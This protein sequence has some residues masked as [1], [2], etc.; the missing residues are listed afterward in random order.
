MGIERIQRLPSLLNGVLWLSCV[1]C[2]CSHRTTEDAWPL[3]KGGS[4]LPERSVP[5]QVPNDTHSAL[6]QGNTQPSQEEA[7]WTLGSFWVFISHTQKI[8]RLSAGAGPLNALCLPSGMPFPRSH[9][10]WI[11]SHPLSLGFN[12][13]SSEK[14][15]WTTWSIVVPPFFSISPCLFPS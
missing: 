3:E 5:E 12:G 10:P 9:S 13:T 8:Y 14:P 4:Q 15:A 6:S 1:L 11:Q 7:R 2:G